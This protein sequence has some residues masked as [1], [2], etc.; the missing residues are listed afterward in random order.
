[1]VAQQLVDPKLVVGPAQANF[2]SIANQNK[3][4][5]WEEESQFAIQA[6]QKNEFLSKCSIH[7]I[8]NSVINVA[9]V[10]LTLNPADGYA[11]LV[12]EY[13]TQTKANECNLRISFK[14]LIKN[15]T[16]TGS[17]VWVKAEIV[18]TEDMFQYNGPTTAPEHSMDPFSDRGLP[19]GV[20]CIAKTA[21]GDILTDIM[22]WDEVLKIQACAK[23]QAVWSKWPE[24]MAKK[25][26]IKRAAKQWPKT[27]KTSILNKTI[28]IINDAEGSDYI[29]PIL[30]LQPTADA[31]LEAITN[32]DES[33]ICEAYRELTRDEQATLFS[34]PRSKGGLLSHKEKTQIKTVLFKNPPQLEDKPEGT[35]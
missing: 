28:A 4:V 10:G 19:V 17:I 32:D 23:T 12:P 33:A 30:A 2:L 13:N 35:E 21:E 20:Y 25:A 18:K 3:L 9:A 31:I 6:L 1:M 8:Q 22:K 29:D 16:D 14:G 7:T 26:I 15:A 24:E 5:K 11:Y 34:V 27:K